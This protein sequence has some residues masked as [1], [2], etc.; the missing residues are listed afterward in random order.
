MPDAEVSFLFDEAPQKALTTGA[1]TI[2]QDTILESAPETARIAKTPAGGDTQN[3]AALQA[4][5]TPTGFDQSEMMLKNHPRLPATALRKTASGGELSR[6]SLA[7]FMLIQQ[8]CGQLLIFDE[9][10][11]GMGGQIGDLL[12]QHL[13]KLSQRQQLLCITHLPQVAARS[14]THIHVSKKTNK[15]AIFSEAVALNNT[16]RQA[17]LARMLGVSTL[18]QALA[19]AASEQWQA[20]PQSA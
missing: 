15:T 11:T 8:D 7:L 1:P 18:P 17:E 4:L 9:V 16:N 12:G 14:D 3:Y 6:I 5:A 19:E 10:D 20:Q 13:Q 2:G